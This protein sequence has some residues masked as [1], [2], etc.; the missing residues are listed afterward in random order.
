MRCTM[1]TVTPRSGRQ[2][3]QKHLDDGA[4]AERFQTL[5]WASNSSEPWLWQCARTSARPCSEQATSSKRLRFRRSSGEANSEH[6]QILKWAILL[7][8]PVEAE[9]LVCLTCFATG[10]RMP[11]PTRTCVCADMCLNLYT[12][13]CLP[14][15]AF[16]SMCMSVLS[17]V[18]VFI[19]THT[20]KLSIRLV[21]ASTHIRV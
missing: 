3:F 13:M 2:L 5:Q 21:S 18:S 12:S 1:S 6:C 20:L 11:V 19:A 9:L 14:M 15:L 17:Y 16:V 4:N 7:D 8:P 10:P